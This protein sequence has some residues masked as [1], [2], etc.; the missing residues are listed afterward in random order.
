MSIFPTSKILAR[1]DKLGQVEFDKFY[2]FFWNCQNPNKTRHVREHIVK[3][4]TTILLID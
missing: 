3:E 1:F 2:Q 4:N